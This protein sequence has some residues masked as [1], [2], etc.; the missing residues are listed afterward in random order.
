MNILRGRCS[1][2]TTHPWT[3]H[4]HRQSPC[5]SKPTTD[6]V[7]PIPPCLAATPTSVTPARHYRPPTTMKNHST[8][9]LTPFPLPTLPLSPA[10]Q[11]SHHMLTSTDTRGR[12]SLSDMYCDVARPLGSGSEPW[13]AHDGRAYDLGV[14]RGG[15][16]TWMRSVRTRMNRRDYERATAHTNTEEW[17]GVRTK[18]M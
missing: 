12:G 2:C 8:T 18:E 13:R 9:G 17:R 3:P 10:I 5:L 6:N 7:S 1:K 14:Q 15:M 16:R 4:S 11:L